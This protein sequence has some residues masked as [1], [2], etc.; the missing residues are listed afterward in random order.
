MRVRVAMSADEKTRWRNDSA[1][2][3]ARWFIE[4]M[5]PTLINNGNGFQIKTNASKVEAFVHLLIIL[6][7]AKVLE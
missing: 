3:C 4:Q 7:G 6:A 2:A 1:L 5:K